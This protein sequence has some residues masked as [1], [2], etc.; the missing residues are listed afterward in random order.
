MIQA[1]IIYSA[2]V[3][4]DNELRQVSG[5]EP[6]DAKNIITGVQTIGNTYERL[7]SNGVPQVAMIVYNPSAVDVSI[8]VRTQYFNV[9]EYLTLNLIAGGI[10]TI[11]FVISTD[12]AR[13]AIAE[14]VFARTASGTANIEYCLLY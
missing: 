13:P 12:E 2:S 7:A 5:S 6:V 10:L 4:V 8:R 11:P 1:T 3:T 9:A 14:D